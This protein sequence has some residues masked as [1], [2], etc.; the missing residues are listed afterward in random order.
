M[1]DITL[2]GSCNSLTPFSEKHS[3]NALELVNTHVQMP[4][5]SV[6]IENFAVSDEVGAQI[7]PSERLQRLAEQIVRTEI[8]KLAI[9]L[10]FP[11]LDKFKMPI[12]L[13]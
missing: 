1:P 12:T 9:N 7:S 5:T 2:E 11:L 3:V 10:M 6:E 13:A 8:R 4:S